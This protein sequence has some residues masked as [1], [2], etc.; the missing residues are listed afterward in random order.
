[1]YKH[2]SFLSVDTTKAGLS[3]ALED[4]VE[5]GESKNGLAIQ[6]LLECGFD[7]TDSILTDF[8]RV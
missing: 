4:D 1:M 3:R 8:Y 6:L 2:A 7:L 5:H